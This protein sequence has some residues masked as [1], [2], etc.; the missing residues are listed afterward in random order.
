M[1]KTV[2]VNIGGIVF[3]IDED[4]YEIFKH[5]LESIRSH[6]TSSEGRDEIMQ[7][8]EARI[9]EMF[10]ERIKDS[11][12]VITLQDVEEVTTVMGKPE[13]ITDDEKKESRISDSTT[14]G[15]TVKRRIFRDPDD[16]LLGGVCSGI[17]NYF[18][19]DP[20]WIRLAWALLFFLGGSGLLLY[21]ILWIIMPEAKT[22][23]DKLQ[24]KGEAVT[25]SNIEKNVKEDIEWKKS[26]ESGA[27]SVLRKFFAAMAEILKFFFVFLGKLIILVMILIGLAVSVSF[28]VVLFGMIGL[29]QVSLPPV[30][31]FVA[32]SHANLWWAYIGAFLAIALPFIMLV[33]AGLRYLFNISQPNRVVN[34]MALALW[35]LGVIICLAIGTRTARQ[36]VFTESVKHQITLQQQNVNTLYLSASNNE[37][38]DKKYD[39]I[40]NWD[41][42]LQ[43][44]VNGDEVSLGNVKLDIVKSSNNQ[45]ELT[46]IMYARGSSR[47]EAERTASRIEYSF[48]QKDSLLTFDRNFDLSENEKY[49][50]QKLQLV[51]KV[52]VGKRI[53]LSENMSHLIYD[54]DNI[55]DVWDK[56]MVSR[57]WEMTDQGLKCIDCTGEEETVGGNKLIIADQDTISV[58][59]SGV[60]ITKNGK[61]IIK[62]D[63]KGVVITTDE[64]K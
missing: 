39:N 10:S 15:N 52:P 25:V 49:R 51:L 38:D 9:A 18:N 56:D 30:V 58:N 55:G 6:F 59:H 53:Y 12:Q 41:D 7:D 1:N 19:I 60:R 32:L 42:D 40:L 36:F 48:T 47:E 11:K 2:T 35:V 24:M 57:T 27:T 62:I 63:D 20:I 43:I 34:Y 4:A 16:K 13:Q 23:A 28:I 64:K 31:H 37:M 3:H 50:M 22:A 5:Y 61:E 44:R 17:A 14:A 29:V 26:N 46:K 45:F 33:Y 54:I 21:I 8:I